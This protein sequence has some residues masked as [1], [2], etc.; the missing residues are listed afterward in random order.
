MV[1][2]RRKGGIVQIR[3]ELPPFP[4]Q[5]FVPGGVL[6]QK[7]AS[8]KVVFVELVLM[9]ASVLEKVGLLG[10]DPVEQRLGA[11]PAREM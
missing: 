6:G 10:D 7:D 8:V 5:S 4:L 9:G 3:Q 2:P 11:E 1:V